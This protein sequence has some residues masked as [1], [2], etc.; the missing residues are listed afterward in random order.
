[1]VIRP[2]GILG[3]TFDPVHLGHLRAAE[4]ARER[5]GLAGVLFIPNHIPPHKPGQVVTAA[6]DRL[7][8]LE[9]AITGH[10]EYAIHELELHR[11]GPSYS[12]DT[13]QILRHEHPDWQFYFI[14][15]ADGFVDLRT[16]HRW[17]ELLQ[18]CFFAIVSRPGYDRQRV[19]AMLAEIGPEL[20]EQ[21]VYLEAPGVDVASSRIRE[22]ASRGEPL[23]G[24]VPEAVAAYIYERGLYRPRSE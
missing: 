20:A 11:T 19:E 22:L 9:L 10:P 2:I 7:A 17:Q 5:L 24:L 18:L 16:W 13:V 14:L 3:G 12:Y 6:A 23:T 8:M 21:V 4:V 1:M 15:G